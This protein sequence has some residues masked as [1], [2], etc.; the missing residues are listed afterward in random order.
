MFTGLIEETGHVVEFREVAGKRRLTVE[1]R[2]LARELKLGDSVAV[3]GVCLTAVKITGNRLS[4]DLAA[5]TIARTSLA[6]LGKGALV[7]LELP[8][9]AESRLG[10]HVVQGHVDGVATLISLKQIEGGEDSWLEV[11][12]PAGLARYVVFKGS[13]ALEGISLTVAR[14]EGR[15]I[16]VAIIPHT[17]TATNLH[18]LKPGALLNV[19]VD[20]IAKY[21]EKMLRGEAPPE[22]ITLE[23]LLGEGF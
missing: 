7:N 14:V 19:E 4:A 2:G 1:T 22:R 8:A 23:R 3:S 12:I 9:K 21:A 17:R 15:R 13:I 5:E 6:G 16:G 20:V 11:E 18:A 10:G